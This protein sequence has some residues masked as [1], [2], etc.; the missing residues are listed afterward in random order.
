MK[1]S[2]MLRIV[3][4]DTLVRE[5]KNPNAVR[6]SVDYEVSARTVMRDIEYIRDQLGAP[7][8]YD[9]KKRGFYYSEAWQMPSVI[10]ISTQKENT[11]FCLLKQIKSLNKNELKIVI[12]AL[13]KELGPSG[14][15]VP[16]SPVA[17]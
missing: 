6:F 7:L 9:R 15:E 14:G 3:E 1:K 16:S 11:I 17:A 8:V 4:F 10:N 12:D 2:Q 5:G 13:L